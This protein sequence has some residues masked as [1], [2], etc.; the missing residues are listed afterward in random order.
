M[1]SQST[2]KIAPFS[3]GSHPQNRPQ[4]NHGIYVATKTYFSSFWIYATFGNLNVPFFPGGMSL[5][6][7]LLIN[8]MAAHLTRLNF[9]AKKAGIWMI[10][11]SVILFIVGGG[12]TVFLANESQL[13]LKEGHQQAYS[14]NFDEVQLMFRR[15]ISAE[16][17]EVIL[18]NQDH[19]FGRQ[20]SGSPKTPYSS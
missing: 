10:H 12:L 1:P 17:D 16:Q 15:P 4:V 11:M 9:T 3:L 19:F 2:I 5:G 13:I 7:V 20:N 8:L 18:F 14:E 6:L